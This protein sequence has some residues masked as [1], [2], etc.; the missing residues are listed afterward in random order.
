MTEVEQ[1]KRKKLSRGKERQKALLPQ[2]L[3]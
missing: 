2:G 1:R 3:F